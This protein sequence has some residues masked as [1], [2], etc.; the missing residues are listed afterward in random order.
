M[1]SLALVFALAVGLIGAAGPAMAACPANATRASLDIWP[2]NSLAAGE[3]VTGTHSC[4][5][6]IRCSAGNPRQVLRRSC[7]WL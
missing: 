2:Q 4:G 3:T 6:S 7:R 5:R 1:K